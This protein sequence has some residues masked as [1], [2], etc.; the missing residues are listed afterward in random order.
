MMWAEIVLGL[1][2]LVGLLFFVFILGAACGFR[3]VYNRLEWVFRMR[4]IIDANAVSIE[5]GDKL[6]ITKH[7]STG[8]DLMRVINDMQA[9][10]VRAAQKYRKVNHN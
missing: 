5:V 9:A 4:G 3:Y 6:G 8:A 7:N 10:Q 1:L 2:C